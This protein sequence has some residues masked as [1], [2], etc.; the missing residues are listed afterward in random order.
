MVSFLLFLTVQ[1]TFYAP[2]NIALIKYWG[3][4]DEDNIIPLNESISVSLDIYTKTR[5]ENSK[6]LEFYLNTIK[7]NLGK[8]PRIVQCV[9]RF[10][11]ICRSRAVAF[12]NVKIETFNQFPTASG[13]ASS[14]SGAVALVLALNDHFKLNLSTEQLSVLAR[15]TSGSACRSIFGN[16]VKWS[17]KESNLGNDLFPY[18]Q[19]RAVP[20]ES[21]LQLFGLIVVLDLQTKKVSSTKGMANT[22][23][24]SILFEKR[25][26]TIEEKI[27]NMEVYIKSNDFEKLAMLTMKDAMNFHACCLDTYP[28]ISYL[29]DKSIAIISNIHDYN[30]NGIKSCYTFDAGANAV[31]LFDTIDHRLDFKVQYCSEMTTIE[32]QISNGPYESK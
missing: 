27:R 4:V 25:M 15:L 10:E 26:E 21:S 6:E 9:S 19:S 18:S 12:T 13:L 29:N 24:T 30:A 2:I 16:F 8:H 22:V 32:C 11:S 20:I 28:P 3:K 14:A 23:K 5:V 17:M 31:L 1:M 7:E